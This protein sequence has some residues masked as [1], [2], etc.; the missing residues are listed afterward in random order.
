MAIYIING[1]VGKHIAF[2]AL[3]DKLAEKGEVQMMTAYPDV[4]RHH[5]KVKASY[6]HEEPGL[7]D[8][9]SRDTDII[10]R[11]PYYSPFVFAKTHLLYEWAKL[12]GIEYEGEL[13]QWHSCKKWYREA[14]EVIKKIPKRKFILVQFGG[15]QSPYDVNQPR[16]FIPQGQRRAYPLN[17]AQDF[18][19]QFTK[20]HPDIA[21][22][23]YS[24]VNEEYSHL[25]GCCVLNTAY[26]LYP[27]LLKASMGFVGI[28]SSL[29][30]M[31]AGVGV[32]GVV[33]WGATG[34]EQFGYPIHGNISNTTNH[35]MRPLC[36]RFGDNKNADGS[37]WVDRDILS[38]AVPVDK[39]M[40]VT[41]AMLDMKLN[42]EETKGIA[43]D[44]CD[45]DDDCGEDCKCK[46]A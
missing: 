30:H 41:E 29:Q 38:T 24:M 37:M 15:G 20:A 12:L 3:I 14:K 46:G 21:V 2:T 27:E 34:P 42:K 13:P 22:V 44:D 35:H 23:N 18:I 5:P 26:W 40:E 32:S 39:L 10:F 1:G 8:R 43:E 11:E 19:N 16:V 33:I 4:F 17:M 36:A 28:D 45:C 25:G 7:Y 6:S 31:A 9:V